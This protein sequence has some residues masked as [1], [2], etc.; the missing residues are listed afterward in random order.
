VGHSLSKAGGQTLAGALVNGAV[1]GTGLYE[2][3]SNQQLGLAFTAAGAVGSAALAVVG[4]HL[5]RF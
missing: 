2:G 4:Y 3:L 1:F 5:G